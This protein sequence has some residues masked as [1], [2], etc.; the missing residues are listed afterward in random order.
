MGGSLRPTPVP[1][2]TQP[3][4]IELPMSSRYKRFQVRRIL[5]H[6]VFDRSCQASHDGYL[7]VVIVF[8]SEMIFADNFLRVEHTGGF[9]IEFNFRDG[10]SGCKYTGDDDERK[11]NQIKVPAANLWKNKAYVMH[12]LYPDNSCTLTIQVLV[13][14]CFVLFRFVFYCVYVF[15]FFS[16]S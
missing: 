9:K 7:L 10:L 5:M 1:S 16:F 12:Y 4:S 6:S 11:T 3:Q 13:M 2:P 8:T 15:C 14:L